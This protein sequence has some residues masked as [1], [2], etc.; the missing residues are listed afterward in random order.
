[1]GGHEWILNRESERLQAALDLII[2]SALEP[3]LWKPNGNISSVAQGTRVSKDDKSG[4]L[5]LRWRTV[6]TV[7]C[8]PT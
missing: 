3:A 5:Q 8:E 6:R 1:M 7:K 4:C 2:N